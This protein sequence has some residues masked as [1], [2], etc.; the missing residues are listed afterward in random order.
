[1]SPEWQWVQSHSDQLRPYAG[2]WVLVDP[3]GIVAHGASYHQVRGEATAKGI[4]IPF[5]FRVPEPNDAVCLGF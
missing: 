2:E 4:S 5:V 1:M 3:S